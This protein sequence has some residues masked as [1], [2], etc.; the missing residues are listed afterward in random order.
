MLRCIGL[1]VLLEKGRITGSYPSITSQND[2]IKRI[3]Q[4]ERFIKEHLM[5][6]FPEIKVEAEIEEEEDG[7]QRYPHYPTL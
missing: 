2:L 6:I 5:R 4:K 3:E 7:T 1:K